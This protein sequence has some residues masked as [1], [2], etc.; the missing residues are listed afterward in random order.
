MIADGGQRARESG[1]AL[2][3]ARQYGE[4]VTFAAL[5]GELRPAELRCCVAEL[6]DAALVAV[7]MAAAAL[8]TQPEALLN[9]VLMSRAAL[10]L[11]GQIRGEA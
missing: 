8:Q 5:L 3:S 6:V 7:H 9:A 4:P 1:R 10:E 11:A 2:L